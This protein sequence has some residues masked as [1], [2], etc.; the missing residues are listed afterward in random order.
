M[1]K[2]AHLRK[3]AHLASLL[4]VAA[5]SLA[6]QWVNYPDKNAPRKPDGSVNFQAPAPKTVDGKPDLSGVWVP[7]PTSPCPRSGCEQPISKEFLNI[8]SVVEGG[9]PYQPWAA[10]LFKKRMAE[11]RVSEPSAHCRP[12]GITRLET[13]PWLRKI[14]QNPGLTLILSERD[15]TFRQIFTD[16]RPLPVDP[17]P[18][19]HGF[20]TGHWEGDTLVVETNGFH[21]DTWLDA[22]GNPLTEAGKITERFHRVNYGR[23]EIQIT[24]NDPKAY[25]RPWTVT[26]VHLLVPDTDLLEYFCTENE[27][28]S[29]HFVIP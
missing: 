12:L 23:L 5:G 22:N 28:D 20:S 3:P 6:A 9:L 18:S 15:V 24:V 21:D 26:V 1:L 27:K 19:W 11:N 8:G 25:T 2:P 7:D 16:G 4:F 13:D 17:Q 29:A 10:A 14:V